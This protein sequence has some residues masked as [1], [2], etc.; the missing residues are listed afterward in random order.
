LSNCCGHLLTAIGLEIIHPDMAKQL[1]RERA[2]RRRPIPAMV[3]L[4]AQTRLG[5]YS[6]TS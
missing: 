6:A 3:G 4:N 5:G 1:R 2:F